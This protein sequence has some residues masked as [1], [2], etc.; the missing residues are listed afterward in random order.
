M[1]KQEKKMFSFSKPC[2]VLMWFL[3]IK[4]AC[5]EDVISFFD[6]KVRTMAD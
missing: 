1:V 5:N 3:L 4:K 2:H 6:L